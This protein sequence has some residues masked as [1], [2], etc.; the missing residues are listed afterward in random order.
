MIS[1]YSQ[2]IEFLTSAPSFM[3]KEEQITNLKLLLHALGNPQEKVRA[4]HVAGTNGKGSVCAYFNKILVDTGYKTGLFTSP[5]LV[6][7]CERIQINNEMICKEDVAEL[8]ERVRKVSDE[9]NVTM[10]QFAYITAIMFLY[11]AQNNVDYA[12]IEVGLGGR[13]DPT[14]LCE[15]C[16]C[17][18]TSISAD[19]TAI[20]GSDRAEIAREKAGIIK[21]GITTVSALQY[22]DAEAV[23]VDTA[24]NACADLFIV[25]ANNVTID[26]NKTEFYFEDE[27]YSISMLGEYQAQNAV[28]AIKGAALLGINGKDIKKSVADTVWRGRLQRIYRSPCVL[29]DGA[30]NPDAA[31]KLKQFFKSINKKAIII[32]A[33]VQDKDTDGAIKHF[34]DFAQYVYCVNMNTP[35]RAS[36]VALLTAFNNNGIC[37]E[38]CENALDALG[39]AVKLW[40]ERFDDDTAIVVCGSLYLVGEFLSYS[41]VEIEKRIT[42]SKGNV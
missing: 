25:N 37:G 19:H 11:F 38:T 20:L 16:L 5:Y 35:R 2:A 36:R 14:V 1:T 13:F 4:I 18:I 42:D 28:I 26:D 9:L 6:D 39:S 29:V 32:C 33:M 12:V 17:A 31:K 24:Q 22:P 15:P 21:K 27:H 40:K 34:A 3:D 23:I 7:F 8:V 41:E 30:H 10:S